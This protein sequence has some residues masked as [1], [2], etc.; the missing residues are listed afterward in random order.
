MKILLALLLFTGSVPAQV[1]DLILSSR[2][3]RSGVKGTAVSFRRVL[4][5]TLKA[6]PSYHALVLEVFPDVIE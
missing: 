2:Q 6:V 1:I 5:Q 4:G 3:K